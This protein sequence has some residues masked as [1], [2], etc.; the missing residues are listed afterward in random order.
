[1][2]EASFPVPNH[3]GYRDVL[4]KLNKVS[5]GGA[6]EWTALLKAHFAGC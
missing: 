3:P 4:L 6:A 1:V 2:V 5:D